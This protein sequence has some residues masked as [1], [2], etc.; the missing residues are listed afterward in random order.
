MLDVDGKTLARA[1]S[2]MPGDEVTMMVCPSSGIVLRSLVAHCAVERTI[3]CTVSSKN[4]ELVSLQRGALASACK[5]LSGGDHPIRMTISGGRATLSSDKS[6]L[7]VPLNPDPQWQEWP[8]LPRKSVEMSVGDIS[9]SLGAVQWAMA[10]D[11]DRGRAPAVCLTPW[12]GDGKMWC[13]SV[14]AM[15]VV[16]CEAAEGLRPTALPSYVSM[17]ISGA[18]SDSTMT[19]NMDD[20]WAIASVP[21]AR[22]RWR[23]DG[24]LLDEAYY[25]EKLMGQYQESLVDRVSVEGAVFS[26]A[27]TILA[28]VGPHKATIRSLAGESSIKI[29]AS[30]ASESLAGSVDVA[31][32]PSKDW[33]CAF[34]GTVLRSAAKCAEKSKHIDLIMAK[35]AMVIS[36]DGRRSLVLGR[37]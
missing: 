31:A 1:L 17:L 23:H 16:P 26:S 11:S 9:S 21:G 19:L 3:P 34:N 24:A 12:V 13:W 22:I 7:R 14:P 27:M 15:S 36:F 29:I 32:S 30:T 18:P 6:R 20:Q 28:A 25:P 37:R 5:A 10:K 35:G 4:E 2:L 33:E 8:N